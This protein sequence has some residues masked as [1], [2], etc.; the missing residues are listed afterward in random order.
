M[1]YRLLVAC[2][3][4]PLLHSAFAIS[5]EDDPLR[6]LSFLEGTWEGRV[7]AGFSAAQS[8]GQYSF[9]REL[10]GH[11]LARRAEGYESCTGPKD[12]DCGHHD[13]LYVYQDAP[14]AL[15]AIYFDNE[16]HVIHYDVATP[17]ANTALFVSTPSTSGPQFRLVY[18]LE[19]ARLSGKFQMRAPGA[20][21]WKSYLEWSGRRRSPP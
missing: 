13:L 18:R 12:F 4:T 17:D 16:G 19:D 8:S 9:T 10:S 21:D 14:H 3:L 2:L 15:R 20:T 11:V 1:K 7:A 6:A 5:A